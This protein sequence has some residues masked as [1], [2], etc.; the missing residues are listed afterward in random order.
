[1]FNDNSEETK[2]NL[3]KFIKYFN[4]K[5]NRNN[6]QYY[7]TLQINLLNSLYDEL[8]NIGSLHYTTFYNDI[9]MPIIN[10]ISPKIEHINTMN[11][12]AT[13]II[14][15][16]IEICIYKR[17][18]YD[19]NNNNIKKNYLEHLLYPIFNLLKDN[20]E[21]YREY[22]NQMDMITNKQFGLYND[23]MNYCYNIVLNLPNDKFAKYIKLLRKI[24]KEV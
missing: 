21:K 7:K 12:E 19:I 10:N 11:N 22:I 2:N 17:Y 9:G 3:R 4:N 5:N 1:M 20:S 14:N 15:K 16:Y 23:Y 13:N 18:K 8:K 24:N 6:S